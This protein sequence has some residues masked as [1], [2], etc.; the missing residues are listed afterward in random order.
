MQTLRVSGSTLIGGKVVMDNS[1]LSVASASALVL[2]QDATVQ[3]DVFLRSG[4]AVKARMDVATDLKVNGTL[5]LSGVDTTLLVGGDTLV[6]DSGLLALDGTSRLMSS[7]LE[8]QGQLQ[9]ISGVTDRVAPYVDLASNLTLKG[10]ISHR[11]DWASVNSTVPLLRANG[12]AIFDSSCVISVEI[13]ISTLDSSATV[14]ILL[15]TYRNSQG[16]PTL[17]PLVLTTLDPCVIVTGTQLVQAPSS[18]SV[19]VSLANTCVSAST[20]QQQQQG[21]SRT[22]IIAVTVSVIGGAIVVA[23]V[24]AVLLWHINR[25]RIMQVQGRIQAQQQQASLGGLATNN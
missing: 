20:Q 25:K 8:V 2:E 12:T 4:P 13:V 14:E 1:A 11:I 24:G 18:L 23:V 15:D 6:Q 22:V 9:L 17:G 16:S 10:R 5:L 19:V 21:V 3:G 7:N